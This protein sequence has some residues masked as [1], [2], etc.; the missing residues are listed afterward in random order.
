MAL[1]V[2]G[3]LAGC[4]GEPSGWTVE[5]P[6]PTVAPSSISEEQSLVD[7]PR[8]S[9][10]Y[11]SADLGNLPLNQ[12]FH[13]YFPFRNVGNATLEIIGEPTIETLEGC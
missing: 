9:F 13:Y 11:D 4:A 12:M 2:F 5:P 3:L 8:I 10:D 1:I 6:T 7:G